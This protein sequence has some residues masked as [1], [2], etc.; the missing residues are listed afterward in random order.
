MNLMRVGF[1]FKFFYILISHYLKFHK[2]F[3]LQSFLLIFNF[4]DFGKRLQ[5]KRNEF[6][7]FNI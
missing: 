5:K 3:I 1:Y 2:K 7:L 4:N 6:I